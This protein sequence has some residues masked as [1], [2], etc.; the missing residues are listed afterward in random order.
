LS[1]G[2]PQFY[3]NISTTR[4]EYYSSSTFTRF[5]FSYFISKS[6]TPT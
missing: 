3:E 6:N 5:T 2:Q 4:Y 1:Y